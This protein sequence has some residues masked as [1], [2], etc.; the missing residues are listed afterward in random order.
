MTGAFPPTVNVI[1]DDTT[2]RAA[3]ARVNVTSYRMLVSGA[4]VA[5]LWA[6]ARE[7]RASGASR[8]ATDRAVLFL[9]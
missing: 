1:A 8:A 7:N 2:R 6:E 5:T 4:E 3:F 9:I